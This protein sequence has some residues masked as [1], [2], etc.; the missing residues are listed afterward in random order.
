MVD[1][2]PPMAVLPIPEMSVNWLPS[3]FQLEIVWLM[4]DVTKPLTLPTALHT[5][6]WAYLRTA[7][8]AADRIEASDGIEKDRSMIWLI[9]AKQSSAGSNRLS[10]FGVAAA[11]SE[12]APMAVR[13]DAP[14]PS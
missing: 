10:T 12:C 11:I 2:A 9:D 8:C 5:F 7:S 1:I 6:F 4:G 14:M 3:W 13:I